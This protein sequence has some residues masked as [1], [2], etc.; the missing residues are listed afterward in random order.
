MNK[1]GCRR[2]GWGYR[3]AAAEHRQGYRVWVVRLNFRQSLNNFS[4]LCPEFDSDLG[5]TH[6]FRGSLGAGAR[7]PP[8][9]VVR[10]ARH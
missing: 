6:I 10:H 2:L 3:F 4:Y 9:S 5:Q 8:R 7:Q 1:R